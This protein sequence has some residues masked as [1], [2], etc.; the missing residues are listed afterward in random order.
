MALVGGYDFKRSKFNRVTQAKRQPGSGFKPV[1]YTT[2]LEKG[3]TAA[4]TINDA[5]IVSRNPSSGEDWRPQNYSGKFYGPT[6]LR[7]ALRKSRNL[8]SIRLLQQL[9]IGPA[10]EIA[11]HPKPWGNK[12]IL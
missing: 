12:V 9:G 4:S 3:Y 7:V 1:L 8:V 2:A 10:T 6:R 11:K 5:P